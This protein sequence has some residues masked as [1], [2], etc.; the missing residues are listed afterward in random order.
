ML[1]EGRTPFWIKLFP[2]S[3]IDLPNNLVQSLDQPAECLRGQPFDEVADPFAGDWIGPFD[4]IDHALG[5][6]V[7]LI[8]F[9]GH[10]QVPGRIEASC[11]VKS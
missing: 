1:E 4:V 11:F 9:V 7:A 3:G 6:S 8:G 10:G 2:D 5:G